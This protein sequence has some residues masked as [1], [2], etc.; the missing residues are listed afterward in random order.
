M[1]LPDENA[2][3]KQMWMSDEV[4]WQT[5]CKLV[6]PKPYLCKIILSINTVTDLIIK[7]KDLLILLILK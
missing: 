5:D 3:I 7:S 4:Y 2:Q 6:C 1:H